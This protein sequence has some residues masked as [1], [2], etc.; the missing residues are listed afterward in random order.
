MQAGFTTTAVLTML[1]SNYRKH[2]SL[3]NKVIDDNFNIKD[4][5]TNVLQKDGFDQKR[6][7]SMDIDDFLA[8]LHNFNSAG[9]HFT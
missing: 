6:A 2:C 1:E 8:L 7:R 4:L 5:V 3:N 9:I